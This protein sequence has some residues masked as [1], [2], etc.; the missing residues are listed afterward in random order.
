MKKIICLLVLVLV[1]VGAFYEVKNF[2]NSLNNKKSSQQNSTASTSNVSSTGIDTNA[3]NLKAADFKLKDLE[4]NYVS[5]SDLKGKKVFLNFWASWCPPC[6]AEMPDIEKIYEENQDK[7]LV[8][9]TINLGEDVNTAKSFIDKNN[10]KFKVLLDFDP[11]VAIDS[12]QSV[13]IK[14]NITS[15]PT[16]FFIDKNGLITAKHVGSMTYE[17]MKDYINKINK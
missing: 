11:S 8:I 12:N 3:F 2:N 16:S 6:K 15:I 14:Y 1:F 5:L 17:Q 9:V 4:G 7:D 13:A 10:Y